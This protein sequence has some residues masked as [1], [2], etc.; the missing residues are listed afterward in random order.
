MCICRE[1]QYVTAFSMSHY[2]KTYEYKFNFNIISEHD[3]LI[4]YQ[5]VGCNMKWL[6]DKISNDDFYIKLSTEQQ[7]SLLNEW[8][9][10][11]LNAAHLSHSAS[12]IKSSSEEYYEVPC[13]ATLKNGDVSDLCI[14]T[15]KSHHPL[16]SRPSIAVISYVYAGQVESIEMSDYALN[17]DIR[18]AMRNSQKTYVRDWCPLNLM[19]DENIFFRSNGLKNYYLEHNFLVHDMYKGRDVVS[20][21]QDVEAYKNFTEMHDIRKKATLILFDSF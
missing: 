16:I 3:H 21:N 19:I 11:D 5:C 8:L 14:L 17:I 13:S 6:L 12:I 9:E 15:K 4:V 1:Y 7:V 2:Q 10:S 20:V 18:I